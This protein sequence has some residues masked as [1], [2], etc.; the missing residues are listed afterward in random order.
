MGKGVQ[1][2]QGAAGEYSLCAAPIAFEDFGKLSLPTGRGKRKRADQ[3]VT[4]A[5]FARIASSASRT[6]SSFSAVL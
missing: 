2:G 4:G 5:A 6:G 3:P 1:P